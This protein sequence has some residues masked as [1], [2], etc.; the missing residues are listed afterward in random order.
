MGGDDM[1]DYRRITLVL[2]RD[3]WERLRQVAERDYRHP[4]DQARAILRRV[5]IDDQEKHNGAVTNLTGTN[6]A[7]AALAG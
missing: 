4:R 5:L 6:G 2:G 1:N 3:E 7:V